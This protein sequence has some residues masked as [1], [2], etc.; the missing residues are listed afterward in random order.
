MAPSGIGNRAVGKTR[1]LTAIDRPM[2]VRQVCGV[3][4]WSHCAR[5][6]SPHRP[7]ICSGQGELY[8]HADWAHP[9]VSQSTTWPPRGLTCRWC[10]E[11]RFGGVWPCRVQRARRPEGRPRA[12][13]ERGASCEHRS[14]EGSGTCRNRSDGSDPGWTEHVDRP[15]CSGAVAFRPRP[16][17]VASFRSRHCSGWPAA[18]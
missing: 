6:R 12:F 8:E 7:G 15:C 16:P 17:R 9:S 1:V 13:G 5:R 18:P 10:A 11:L 3:R 4:A 14:E 2:R